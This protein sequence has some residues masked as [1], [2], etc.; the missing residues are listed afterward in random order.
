MPRRP[1]ARRRRPPEPWPGEVTQG[2]DDEGILLVP[3]RPTPEQ[4]SAWGG[5]VDEVARRI[6]ELGFRGDEEPWF[7]GT[8]TARDALTAGLF[9]QR[10]TKAQSDAVEVDAYFEFRARAHEAHG[11]GADGWDA[12]FFMQHYGVPTRLLDWTATL[13]TA[14]FVALEPPPGQ[15][16]EDLHAV[17]HVLNPFALNALL[18]ERRRKVLLPEEVAADYAETLLDP[19]EWDF[20]VVALYP[21]HKSARQRAQRGFF[22]FHGAPRDLGRHRARERFLRSVPLP[23]PAFDAARYMLWL[24]GT[25]KYALFPE[26]TGLGES[27]ARKYRLGRPFA[28]ERRRERER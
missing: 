6:E 10:L 22:T 27:I 12:L 26:L 4:W 11:V 9:R 15:V 3:P 13:H 23:R 17:V 5:F 21:S 24:A 19:R 18:P 20:D 16:A 1:A 7:R 28:E 14:V 8:D 2:T 25:D